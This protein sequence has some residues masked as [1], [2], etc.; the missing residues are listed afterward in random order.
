MRTRPSCAPLQVYALSVA[1]PVW[2]VVGGAVVAAS[3]GCF[4]EAGEAEGLSGKA[5]A[6]SQGVCLLIGHRFT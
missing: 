3:Q 2:Q 6:C 4:L 1:R 5:T